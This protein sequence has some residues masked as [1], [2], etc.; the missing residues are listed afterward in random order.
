MPSPSLSLTDI[1]ALT[2][3]SSLP[4]SVASQER[5]F[6][7]IITVLT[8]LTSAMQYWQG[9]SFTR[10]F[11]RDCGSCLIMR[12]RYYLELITVSCLACIINPEAR[13]RPFHSAV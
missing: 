10:L 7:L 8:P 11:L 12:L 5:V 6:T 3:S 4:P 13:E 2:L 9:S 1:H